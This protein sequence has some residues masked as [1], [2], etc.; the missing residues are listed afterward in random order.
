VQAT[1]AEVLH[2]WRG[3]EPEFLCEPKSTSICEI[4]IDVT[5]ATYLVSQ[6]VKVMLKHERAG[7]CAVDEEARV[8]IDPKCQGRDQ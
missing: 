2:P 7:G 6:R 4:D 1:R 8:R 3:T 5:S